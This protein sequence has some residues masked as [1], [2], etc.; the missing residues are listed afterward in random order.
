MKTVMVQMQFVHQ[1]A[2]VLT[3]I[4]TAMAQPAQPVVRMW[5]WIAM[6]MPVR[7]TLEL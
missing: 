6:I 2:I 4:M 7:F 1:Q 3:M 5:E